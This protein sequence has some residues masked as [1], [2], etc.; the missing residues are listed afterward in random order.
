M[1]VSK[2]DLTN[3]SCPVSPA[4]VA[5]R[6]DKLFIWSSVTLICLISSINGLIKV[7]STS[8]NLAPVMPWEFFSCKN[9]S[10]ASAIV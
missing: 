10:A 6:T 3:P 7:F 4:A 1:L 2:S 5:D 8:S 9:V